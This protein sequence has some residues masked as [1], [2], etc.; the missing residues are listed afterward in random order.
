MLAP[1]GISARKDRSF[2]F[3]RIFLQ[4]ICAQARGCVFCLGQCRGRPSI[5]VALAGLFVGGGQAAEH[6]GISPIAATPRL[7]RMF[8]E[9]RG[10]AAEIV[11]HAV[12]HAASSVIRT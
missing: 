5:A 9:I 6:L 10:S 7:G 11:R 1:P 8:L 2:I 3:R 12:L 4:V